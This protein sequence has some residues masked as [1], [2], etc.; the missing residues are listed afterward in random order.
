MTKPLYHTIP[1]APK[2]NNPASGG[3]FRL[4]AAVSATPAFSN[5]Q[6]T[7]DC[8]EPSVVS[9][10]KFSCLPTSHGR[11]RVVRSCVSRQQWPLGSGRFQGSPSETGPLDQRDSSTRELSDQFEDI[12]FTREFGNTRWTGVSLTRVG[13]IHGKRTSPQATSVQARDRL[14]S[15]FE[16][17]HSNEC[18]SSRLPGSSVGDDLNIRDIP[19]TFK[20]GPQIGGRRIIGEIPHKNI[21]HNP[22]LSVPIV[23][24]KNS[25]L[26]HAVTAFSGSLRFEVNFR[27]RSD[28]L[29]AGNWDRGVAYWQTLD[30]SPKKLL[31]FRHGNSMTLVESLRIKLSAACGNF[32]TSQA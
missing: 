16:V 28:N 30:E 9:R 22:C 17:R 24:Q 4:S 19:I 12:A 1:A 29:Q 27:N 2:Q 8:A 6:R 26:V 25:T 13:F 18:K 32:R 21:G 14:F 3:A 31:P 11:G 7:S 23:F 15:I 5:G 10:L 20:D